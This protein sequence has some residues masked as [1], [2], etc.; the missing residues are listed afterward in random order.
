MEHPTVRD[1]AGIIF[2]G[3]DVNIASG[4][5]QFTRKKARKEK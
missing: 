4:T 5:N 3:L 2:H 1:G